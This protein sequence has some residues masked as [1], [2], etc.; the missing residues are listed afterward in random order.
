MLASASYDN[1]IKLI[2]EYDGEWLVFA[3]LTGHTSTVWSISWDKSGT[4]LVS[5]SDDKTIRIWQRF[6]VNNSEGNTFALLCNLQSIDFAKTHRILKKAC[7][8]KAYENA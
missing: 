8:L 7:V 2:K 3:T 4:R 1:S 6:D 5:G